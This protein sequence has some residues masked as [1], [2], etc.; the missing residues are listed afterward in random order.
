MPAEP[1]VGR[2]RR[3]GVSVRTQAGAAGWGPGS[4]CNKEGP[5]AVGG[6]AAE[7]C[8]ALKAPAA[9][10]D[11]HFARSMCHL[12][13]EQPLCFGTVLPICITCRG[14]MP[15]V[16][17]RVASLCVAVALRSSLAWLKLAGVLLETRWSQH[18]IFLPGLHVC[19]GMRTVT[20]LSL[21]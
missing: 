4:R 18:I 20:V 21:K 19:R 9:F 8:P 16:N 5:W 3:D 12:P 15:C 2:S 14:R 7:P 17:V 13:P 10:R 6:G 11:V 1:E